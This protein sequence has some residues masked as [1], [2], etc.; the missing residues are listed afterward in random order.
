MIRIALDAM[1]GD[2]APHDVVHGGIEAART[3][4]DRFEVVLVGERSA[5]EKE[6]TRHFHISDLPLSIVDAAQ[7]VTMDE[8]PST[9]LK[10]KDSSIAIAMGLHRDKKVQA[11]VSAGNTGA[12]MAFALFSLKRV[13]GIRRPAIGSIFPSET[14]AVLLIDV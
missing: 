1:G 10:K 11:V 13:P 9:A 5:I 7:I 8:Q 14:G 4:K 6:V 3:S 2:N 12:I